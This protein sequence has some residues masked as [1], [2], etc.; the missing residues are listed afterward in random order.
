MKYRAVLSERARR[1]INAIWRHS[2]EHWGAAQADKYIGQVRAG[3]ETL[4]LNPMAG[5][6]CDDIR[7]GCRRYHAGSHVLFYRIGN[8]TVF[9]FRVLHERMDFGQHL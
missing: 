2:A 3:V 1:D 6:A 8:A 9:V 4:A 7:A 5:G